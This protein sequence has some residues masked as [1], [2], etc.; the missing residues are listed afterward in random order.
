MSV[1]FTLISC[2]SGKVIIHN[3]DRVA[4]VSTSKG[5]TVENFE[6]AE[7]ILKDYTLE[8]TIPNPLTGQNSATRR[9]DPNHE[10]TI[11]CNATL[12]DDISTEADIV[13]NC[14]HDSLDSGEC[15]AYR[16]KYLRENL[17]DG[18]FRIRVSMESGFSAKS[19]DPD[20]WVIYIEN[21][22]GVVIEPFEIVA[23]PVTSHND[24][25]YSNYYRV[26]MSRNLLHRDVNLYF[27]RNT[28]FGEDLLGSDNPYFVLVFTYEKKTLARVAWKTY[29]DLKK[30]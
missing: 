15:E 28:F 24:S 22:K 1:C 16:E 12:L 3:T 20:H 7:K 6:S 29:S 25:V 30:K 8:F 18:T 9:I 10:D 17:K 21:V 27:K 19:M 5:V 11:L 2:G 14:H 4:D 23:T 26:N 13:Y